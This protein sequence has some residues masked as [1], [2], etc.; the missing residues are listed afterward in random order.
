MAGRVAS[1]SVTTPA[2]NV[3]GTAPLTRTRF[4]FCSRK[5]V[6]KRGAAGSVDR[7]RNCSLVPLLLSRTV[8]LKT[9]LVAS[10]GTG[11]MRAHRASPHVPALAAFSVK[12]PVA[13]EAG[14]A[15]SDLSDLTEVAFDAFNPAPPATLTTSA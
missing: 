13:A 7:L 2:T 5:L 9:L 3:A 4:E 15:G 1:A 6:T 8:W 10:P 12:A 14:P 11:S